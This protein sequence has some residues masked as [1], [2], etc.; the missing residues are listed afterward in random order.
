MIMNPYEVYPI[1][2]DNIIII[3]LTHTIFIAFH[4]KIHGVRPKKTNKKSGLS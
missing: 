3:T 4:I 2:Y 1:P